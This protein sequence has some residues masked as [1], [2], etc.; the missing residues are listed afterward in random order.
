MRVV[1]VLSLL[2]C[3]TACDEEAGTPVDGA[4]QD[5]LSLDQA[6]A[7]SGAADK[8]AVDSA[9]PDAK[10]PDSAV[11]DKATPDKATPDMPAKA[12]AGPASCAG[13]KKAVTDEIAR[14]AKCTATSECTFLWGV[15]PFGC[16][17]PHNKSADLTKYN[18]AIATFQK[19]PLCQKCTY[20]C[21]QPG[22]LA[23]TGGKCA[24]TYP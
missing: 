17:I 10:R 14:M 24:M 3:L 11:L 6:L 15:C 21:G 5:T 13:I 4:V 20:K 7:D 8:A 23:C 16:H 2:V 12:D 19:S 9:S 22:T 1:L 18:A